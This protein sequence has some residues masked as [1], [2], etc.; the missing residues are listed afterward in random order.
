MRE[1]HG[2]LGVEAGGGGDE[3][4]TWGKKSDGV[5]G[6]VGMRAAHKNSVSAE[7]PRLQERHVYRN[8]DGE[9]YAGHLLR[10]TT[11]IFCD[12]TRPPACLPLRC[13]LVRARFHRAC[14]GGGNALG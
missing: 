11:P 10:G 8:G 9:G 2:G 5:N 12:R 6:R 3:A 7:T 13:G 1:E 14:N 4:V